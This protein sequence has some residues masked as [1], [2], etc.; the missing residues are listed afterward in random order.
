MYKIMKRVDGAKRKFQPIAEVPTI[1]QAREY[2][3]NHDCYIQ[4]TEAA[5]LEQQIIRDTVDGRFPVF[6]NA[7]VKNPWEEPVKSRRLI[8]APKANARSC[9]RVGT[10]YHG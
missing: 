3:S 7:C 9:I 1:K 4:Y 6:F 5:I 10:Y 8:K 2:I